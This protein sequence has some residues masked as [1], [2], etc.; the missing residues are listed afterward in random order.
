M[1]W[2]G[3]WGIIGGNGG[4]F[5]IGLRMGVC[6]FS[7]SVIFSVG[8]VVL[9][10]IGCNFCRFVDKIFDFFIYCNLRNIDEL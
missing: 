8:L 7:R 9:L 6:L 4:E 5:L 10:V 1:G 3:G 2:L